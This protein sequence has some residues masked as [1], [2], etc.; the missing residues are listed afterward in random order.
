MWEILNKKEPIYSENFVKAQLYSK[1]IH[2]PEWV[3][4]IKIEGYKRLYDVCTTFDKQER[5][6]MLTSTTALDE[7]TQTGVPF[8]SMEGGIVSIIGIAKEL[9][10]AQKALQL[11]PSEVG[12]YIWA[13]ATEN[14]QTTESTPWEKFYDQFQSKFSV[15]MRKDDKDKKYQCFRLI[16]NTRASSSI[17]KKIWENFSNWFKEYLTSDDKVNVLI[18][19]IFESSQQYWFNGFIDD[20]RA[21]DKLESKKLL[22]LQK[23]THTIFYLIRCTADPGV[24]AMHYI[25]LEKQGVEPV[26][27]KEEIRINIQ[28]LDPIIP[29][30]EKYI[31][32]F[33][34][35][36]KKYEI[37]ELENGARSIFEEI[38]GIG[39]GKDDF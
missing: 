29:E 4:D 36:Y 1:E 24:F 15:V 27:G 7:E 9:K 38:E 12:A 17:N 19:W 34:S 21:S 37:R 39:Y 35:K 22:I 25:I 2:K 18:D 3:N 13:K 16:L 32:T 10:L 28:Q 23:V 26:I 11:M 33:T 6:R 8:I 20:H 30:L 14:E 5:V 31:R